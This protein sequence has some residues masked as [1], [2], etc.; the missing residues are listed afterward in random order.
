MFIIVDIYLFRL[1][2][3]KISFIVN[4]HLTCLNRSQIE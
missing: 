3:E 1:S 2:A 4:I